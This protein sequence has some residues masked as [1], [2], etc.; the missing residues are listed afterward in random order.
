MIDPLKSRCAKFRFR[1]V[2][3]A[4][5]LAKLEQICA[6]E[7]VS[8]A[9]DRSACLRTLLALTSGDLRRAVGL[10]QCAHQLRRPLDVKDLE[11]MAGQ[12][13]EAVM[14]EAMGVLMGGGEDKETVEKLVKW[15]NVKLAR[16]GYPAQQFIAQVIMRSFLFRSSTLSV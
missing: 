15:V 5:G 16:A 8:F 13:P 14:R 1:P 10:L 12:V 6:A 9:G 2:D 4:E 7:Q 11:E 3:P